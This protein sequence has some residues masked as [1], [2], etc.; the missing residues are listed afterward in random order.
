MG[1]AGT[2]P[3]NV[4]LPFMTPTNTLDSVDMEVLSFGQTQG[5]DTIQVEVTI[6]PN[7]PAIDV[8]PV[9][10]VTAPPMSQIVTSPQIYR[11]TA[12]DP[13]LNT[14]FDN[15]IAYVT[16]AIAPHD[17]TTR[18]ELSAGIPLADFTTLFALKSQTSPPYKLDFTPTSSHNG[19]NVFIV[20]ATSDDGG[21]NT[22]S[23][24]HFI[25]VE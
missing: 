1:G 3:A 16:M 11:A 18:S 13:Q 9:I 8:L 21:R 15:G 19:N 4:P 12:F 17:D 6:D 2:I 23:L 24:E 5:F 10:D 25:E 7:R 14:L 22:V 20:Q